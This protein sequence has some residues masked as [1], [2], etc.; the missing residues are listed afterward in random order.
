MKLKHTLFFMAY[1]LFSWSV[2]VADAANAEKLSRLLE[3]R[4]DYI[5]ALRGNRLEEF[6]IGL[7]EET[8]SGIKRSYVEREHCVMFFMQQKQKGL[9]L[10]QY[11][12]LS[13]EGELLKKEIERTV[14]YFK[15][16]GYERIVLM[17][18]A[19][20]GVTVLHDSSGEYSSGLYVEYR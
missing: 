12:V 9:I 17:Q 13:L 3:A 15:K 4:A 10:V 19:N 7:G 1:A 5:V 18:Y 14:S 11:L 8:P 6:D 20:R 2:L 16:A